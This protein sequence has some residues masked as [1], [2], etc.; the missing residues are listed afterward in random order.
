MSETSKTREHLNTIGVVCRRTGLKSDRLRAWE[1][2]YDVVKPIRSGGNQRLYSEDDVE[3]LLDG[4]PGKGAPPFAAASR[5]VYR[6][7]NGAAD[8]RHCQLL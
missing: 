4:I 1:R 5:G 2:R 6:L 3:K 8:H 7:G